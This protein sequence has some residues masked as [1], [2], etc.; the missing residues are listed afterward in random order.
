MADKVDKEY[1]SLRVHIN[2]L[3]RLVGAFRRMSDIIDKD[4]EKLDKFDEQ[5]NRFK[6]YKRMVDEFN[7]SIR[8]LKALKA[9]F[10]VPSISGTVATNSLPSNSTVNSNKLATDTKKNS[11]IIEGTFRDLT[12]TII[13]ETD[14]INKEATNKWANLGS[15]ILGPLTRQTELVNTGMSVLKNVSTAGGGLRDLVRYRKI[16]KD[17]KDNGKLD[18]IA[19]GASA[20]SSAKSLASAAGG[21]SGASALLFVGASLAAVVGGLYGLA[22]AGKYA[23]DRITLVN[24]ALTSMGGSINNVGEAALRAKNNQI[25]FS[26]KID[27]DLYALSIKLNKFFDG[28]MARAVDLTNASGVGEAPD[29]IFSTESDVSVR[30]QASGFTV[31]SANNLAVGTYNLANSIKDQWGETASDIADKLANA[32]LT[33]S[34]AAAKYGAVLDDLTLKGY[35]ASK[36]VDIVN[37]EITDAME[38]YYRYQLLEEE[39]STNSRDAMSQNIKGWREYGN[40]I[41]KTKQKLFGFDEVIQLASFNPEIPDIAGSGLLDQ[42]DDLKN[43]LNEDKNDEYAGLPGLLADA[44]NK[45]VEAANQNAKAAA[46]AKAA[47]ENAED[48]ANKIMDATDKYENSAKDE[49]EA[50]EQ[51]TDAANKDI[52]ASEQANEAAENNIVAAENNI[53]ASEN[54][55]VAADTNMIAANNNTTASQNAVNA[56]NTNLTA[57]QNA[58][59]AANQFNDDLSNVEAYLADLTGIEMSTFTVSSA[60]GHNINKAMSGEEALSNARNYLSNKISSNANSN[61]NSGF[62]GFTIP[63]L[64]LEA[65]DFINSFKNPETDKYEFSLPML[66]DKLLDFGISSVVSP[67]EAF[68]AGLNEGNKYNKALGVLYGLLNTGTYFVAEEAGDMLNLGSVLSDLDKWDSGESYTL[69]S[70]LFGTASKNFDKEVLNKI[71]SSG[72]LSMDPSKLGGEGLHIPQMATGGIGTKEGLISAFENDKAEAVIPLETQAGVDYLA[73]AMREAGGMTGAGGNNI[74]V[75]LNVGMMVADNEEQI[76][77]LTRMISDKLGQ[78]IEDR[79]SLDYG[80]N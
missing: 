41:D 10:K 13:K 35:M 75:N 38:Q 15:V 19:Y 57:S 1:T 68:K 64:I 58:I 27:N 24:Q 39:L 65:G 36:G 66:G 78:L 18:D 21:A 59:D 6:D 5:V 74:E 42:I 32:W 33:G 26:N 47:A 17:I 77:R 3:N 55:I 54:D 46:D 49:L 28:L 8:D 60:D 14:K 80:S 56:A 50:A 43:K 45:M 11:K 67:V 34:D 16:I 12:T 51:S 48:A 25:E 30:A 76:D 22:K 37:V 61:S 53:A 70:D 69:P 44:A 2:Q 62:F 72:L 63:D 7:S 71:T 9:G 40:I 31:G 20:V 4:N 23:N 52:E 73:N 29:K 79:G